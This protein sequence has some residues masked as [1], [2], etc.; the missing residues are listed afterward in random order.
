MDPTKKSDPYALFLMIAGVLLLVGGWFTW[1]QYKAMQGAE[2][3]LKLAQK[4]WQ[5][6][7]T[8]EKQIRSFPTDQAGGGESWTLTD[9]ED[10]IRGGQ[11]P[12][13]QEKLK[14]PAG[15][16]LS[17]KYHLAV[18]LRQRAQSE[19]QG[20]W[21]QDTLPL[22]AQGCQ[23]QDLGMFLSVIEYLFPQ[24]RTTRVSFSKSGDKTEGNASV[25]I[26][27]YTEKEK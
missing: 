16:P 12:K 24:A 7:L 9:V 10:A 13:L 22:D 27:M 15:Q 18:N 14:L 23:L 2:S 4:A 20:N 3:R 6:A 26:S 19:V 11:N 8:M 21:V 25:S 5:D 17:T 1:S